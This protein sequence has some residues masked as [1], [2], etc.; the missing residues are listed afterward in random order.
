LSYDVPR[1][2]VKF[3][4][5]D[6][7]PKEIRFMSPFPCGHPEVDSAKAYLYEVKNSDQAVVFVHGVGRRRLSYLDFYPERLSRNGFTAI[8]PVLPFHYDRVVQG[9]EHYDKFIKGPT[10]TMERKF[11]QAVVDIR[12]CVDFLEK[13]GYEHIHIMG[14][15]SGGMIATITMAVD[16]RIE[17]GVLIITGGNLEI[18]SWHSIGTKIY[19][20]GKSWRAHKEKSLEIQ[21]E[22]DDCARSFSSIEDLERIPSFFRYDP[23]LF[24][25]LIDNSGVMMFSAL[26]DPWIPKKSSDDLWRRL[27]EPVRVMLPSGHLTSHLLFKRLILNRSVEFLSRGS[28]R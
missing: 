20:I 5:L 23:S 8:M 16:K 22:L 14:V 21:K 11:Y 6:G 13:S 27:G 24:A 3:Y 10:E 19:R 1:E 15:S 28:V 4:I 17:R 12:T 26:L 9:H 25:K 7:C 2:S 18:I